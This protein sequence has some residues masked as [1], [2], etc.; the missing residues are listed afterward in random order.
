MSAGLDPLG[1][2]ARVQRVVLVGSKFMPSPCE[3]AQRSNPRH[4]TDY[5]A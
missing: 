1:F 3:M 4:M 5:L 2:L